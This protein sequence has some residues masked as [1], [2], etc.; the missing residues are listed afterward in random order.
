[1]KL[2]KSALIMVVIHAAILLVGILAAYLLPSKLTV[3]SNISIWFTVIAYVVFAA[4]QI[5]SS[6]DQRENHIQNFG[7]VAA[8]AAYFVIAFLVS[9]VL[10]LVHPAVRIH[11]VLELIVL[12]FGIVAVGLMLLAKLHI[13]S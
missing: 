10:A 12:V 7:L 3:N 11:I 4:I 1:M 13:E 9:I 8:A 6:M 2:T 5:W